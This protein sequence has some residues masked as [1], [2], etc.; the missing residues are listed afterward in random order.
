MRRLTRKMKMWIWLTLSEVSICPFI[1][2]GLG[3][4]FVFW[5]FGLFV[6]FSFS[7]FL[8]SGFWILESV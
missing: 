3:K 5:S 1:V 6:F 7:Q 2:F 8:E 4:V